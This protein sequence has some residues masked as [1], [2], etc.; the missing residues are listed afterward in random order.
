MKKK[1]NLGKDTGGGGGGGVNFFNLKLI[2][3]VQTFVEFKNF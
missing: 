1:K 3:I 2:F